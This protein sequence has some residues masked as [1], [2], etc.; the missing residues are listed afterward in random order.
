MIIWQYCIWDAALFLLQGTTAFG[1]GTHRALGPLNQSGER[2]RGSCSSRLIT[3]TSEVQQHRDRIRIGKLRKDGGS[4]ARRP[5][6]NR[7]FPS[8]AEKERIGGLIRNGEARRQ[9]GNGAEG[10]E[11]L[12][13]VSALLQLTGR[14]YLV[15]R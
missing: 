11:A 4:E 3:A 10:L 9:L 13:V 7:E 14:D 15:G 5:V 1:F 12:S 8:G 2:E 6:G